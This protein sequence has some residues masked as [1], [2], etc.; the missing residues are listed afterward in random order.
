M[1]LDPTT[2]PQVASKD[3]TKFRVSATSDDAGLLRTSAVILDTENGT[4]PN[5]VVSAIYQTPTSSMKSLLVT[6]V[7]PAAEFMRVSAIPQGNFYRYVSAASSNNVSDAPGL[8][9]TIV[10]CDGDAKSIYLY[11]SETHGL[12]QIG[13]LDAPVDGTYT[14]D[15]G[16]SAGLTVSCTSASNITVNYL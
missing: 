6:A 4:S 10:I 9:H 8:L 2:Y 5:V 15:C 7:S 13:Y 16:L 12:N 11:D 1:V 14:F 3:A